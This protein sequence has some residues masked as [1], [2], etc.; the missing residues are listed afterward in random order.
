MG[1]YIFGFTYSFLTR[2]Y[3]SILNLPDLL[4]LLGILL[5]FF[6]LLL[7]LDGL[8]F[9]KFGVLT[10]FAP[11]YYLYFTLILYVFCFTAT[12]A[13]VSQNIFDYRLRLILGLR[14]RLSTRVRLYMG[15]PIWK[16]MLIHFWIVKYDNLGSF[17]LSESRLICLWISGSISNF[18]S[19]LIICAIYIIKIRTIN[20]RGWCTGVQLSLMILP[21]TLPILFGLCDPKGK[22][23]LINYLAI[24]HVVRTWLLWWVS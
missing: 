24:W 1:F 18:R 5:L 14:L 13:Q 2:F 7:F 11:P 8:A 16:L 9:I 19:I 22:L 12:W 3:C 4:I 17:Y 6:L 23:R 15:L 20:Y 21:Y 10:N